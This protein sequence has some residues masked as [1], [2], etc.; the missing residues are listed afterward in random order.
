MINYKIISVDDKE[1][2]E[3]KDHYNDESSHSSNMVDHDLVLRVW[4]R[5]I[6]NY[7]TI[8]GKDLSLF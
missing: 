2:Y 7:G 8:F 4:M 6:N 5:N 3:T 1:T